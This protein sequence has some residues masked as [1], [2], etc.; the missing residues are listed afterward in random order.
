MKVVYVC[1]SAITLSLLVTTMS[2]SQTNEIS[3]NDAV[4]DLLPCQPF[5]VGSQQ[6][7]TVGCC[8]GVN[9]V[10]HMA[11]TTQNR[12]DLCECLKKLAAQIGVKPERAKALPQFCGI[13]L[14]FP[15]DPNVD[16]KS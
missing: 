11:D 2:G 8:T 7:P 12:R 3:C 9:I 5:L 1:V 10:F 4:S 6:N 15:M 13:G 16:C 14:P